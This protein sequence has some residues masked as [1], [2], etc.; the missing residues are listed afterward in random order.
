MT[1]I[2]QKLIIS[3]TLALLHELAQTLPTNTHNPEDLK[4]AFSACGIG[5][6]EALDN[7]RIHFSSEIDKATLLALLTVTVDFILDGRLKDTSSKDALH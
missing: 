3:P 5:L 4:A 1:S 6:I 7:N 2:E